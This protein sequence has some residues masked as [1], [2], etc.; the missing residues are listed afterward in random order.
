MDLWGTQL[1]VLS[2]CRT[3]SGWVRTGQ[4]VY[5]LRRAFFIAGAE[6]LVSSL[7]DVAD[8]ETSTLMDRYYQQLLDGKPRAAAMQEAMQGLRSDLAKQ[9]TA[10]RDAIHPFY[11]APFI[12]LGRDAPLSFVRN[13]RPAKAEPR[14]EP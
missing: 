9:W 4:G 3:G 8:Q 2:A 12:V 14:K 1:V 6:T 13:P 5:G 10:A 11:W 7:W